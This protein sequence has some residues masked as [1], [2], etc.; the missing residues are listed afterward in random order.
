MNNE[1]FALACDKIIKGEVQKNGIGTLQEKTLHKI[2]KCYFEPFD[3]NQE[4]KIGGFV[5]DIVGENGIIEIQTRQFNA[6][7]KKLEVF[8][9]VGKVTVVY[10]IAHIKW[11][12]WI[13]QET[14]QRT[15]RRKSPKVGQI[16]SILDELYKIKNLLTNENLNFC[17]VLID[18]EEYRYLNGWSKDKKKGSSRYDRIPTDIF[19]EIYIE[20]LNNYSKLIPENLPKAFTTRDYKT[21][22]GLSLKSAQTALNVLHYIDVIKRVGKKGNLHIYE[23]NI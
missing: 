12:V 23:K 4:I 10:P 18:M 20:G 6:M 22:S 9:S 3:I 16:Y 19:D 15:N 21:A 1:L 13:D 11:L 17:I 14:G 5:A 8:L 2:L 7:R